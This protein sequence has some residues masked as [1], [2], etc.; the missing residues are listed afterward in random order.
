[1][2][3]GSFVGGFPN[4]LQGP[5]NSGRREYVSLSILEKFRFI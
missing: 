4:F 5:C 3:V 2:L 1:M